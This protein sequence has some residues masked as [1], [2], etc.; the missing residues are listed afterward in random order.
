MNTWDDIVK[1]L[2]FQ[3]DD[4]TYLRPC[5]DI[6]LY[7][8]G[9]PFARSD[10]LREGIIAFYNRC[11]ETVG[12]DFKFY[13][14]ET[15]SRDRPVKKDTLGL[16][17]L[18]FQG[19]DTR[20]DIYTL[21]LESATRPEESSD[22]AFILEANPLNGF[23]RLVLPLSFIEDSTLPLL[24]L[25]KYLGGIFPFDFGLA[26]LSVNWRPVGLGNY[27]RLAKRTLHALAPRYSGLELP[28]PACTAYIVSKGIKC[29]NWLTFL[30]VASCERLG[31]V[32]ALQKAFD[33][34][35][36]VHNLDQHGAIIQAGP[37]PAL[38]DVN[39]QEALPFYHQVG[40]VLAPIRSQEHPAIFGPGGFP[41]DDATNEWLARFDS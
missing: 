18:W 23:V 31:G 20:R 4:I 37:A 11:I 10:G 24:D 26:G 39:R 9:S 34:N 13:R 33:Q 2:T 1:D 8:A 35:V 15:M 14:T 41:D 19:T 32:A 17:P 5:L 16:L 25:S 22:R 28:H 36:V 29:V 38:G 27:D 3:K 6:T 40:R 12:S 21:L 30:N 7:W